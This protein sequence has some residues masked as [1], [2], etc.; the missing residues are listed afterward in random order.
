MTES[1][2][3]NL[4]LILAAAVVVL[5]VAG[6]FAFSAYHDR[7]ASKAFSNLEKFLATDNLGGLSQEEATLLHNAYGSSVGELILN[8]H[9][10]ERLIALDADF[11]TFAYDGGRNVAFYFCGNKFF[12]TREYENGGTA[13]TG[14]A[15]LS[16][17]TLVGI[18]YDDGYIYLQIMTPD[19]SLIHQVRP[20]V[21]A[22]Y[23]L[24]PNHV[25]TIK[26]HADPLL[27]DASFLMEEIARGK[28]LVLPEIE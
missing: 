24:K 3:L 10:R 2:R 25:Y 18:R 14:H 27:S 20:Q 8:R 23:D 16:N 15:G 21:G 7:A 19:E 12:M 22:D 5:M 26:M 6:F 13:G 4:P 11:D 1:K 28:A 17:T 9:G